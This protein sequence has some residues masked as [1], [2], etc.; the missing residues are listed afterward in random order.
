MVL[1]IRKYPDSALRKRAREIEIVSEDIKKLGQDMI[2]T[3]IV[4]AGVGL[5]ANQIGILKRIMVVQIEGQ[6]QIFINPVIIKID[7][8]KEV[9]TEGC[10][11]VSGLSLEVRRSREVEVKGLNI[12][13]EKIKIK[14]KD[15][16]ARI[17]QHEIDHLNG[18]L[19]ID[20][21]G[22]WQRLKLKRKLK[23]HGPY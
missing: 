17:F 4:G 3:M 7:R 23:Q 14:A 10:L 6:P 15:L 21:I 5:A 20:R 2:E 19:I 22:F 16:T 1:E 11:S 9:D 18:I 8:R 13:G 12:N